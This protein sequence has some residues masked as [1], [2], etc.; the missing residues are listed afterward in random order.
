MKC[1]MTKCETRSH[2]VK[3]YEDMQSPCFN[4]YVYVTEDDEDD[5]EVKHIQLEY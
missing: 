4:K 1:T 5:D 3:S 2:L